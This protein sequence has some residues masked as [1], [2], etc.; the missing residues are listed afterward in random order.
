MCVP[1]N[2]T[3]MK[4][5]SILSLISF[6]LF[7]CAK[8]VRYDIAIQNVDVF[9]SQHKIV[10]QNKTILIKHDSIVAIV[11]ADK[12]ISAAKKIEGKGRLVTSGFVDTHIHLRQMLDLAD[13]NA[14]KVL[15]QTYRKKLAQKLLNFGITTALDMGQYESWIPTTI[16][17]QQNPS[18][19]YPNYYVT[20]AGMIS[21]GT[22]NPAPHHMVV[23][24]PVNKMQQYEKLGLK[25]VKLH[26]HLDADDMIILVEEATKRNMLTFLHCDNNRVTIQEA[27]LMG[28]R[29]FEHFFTVIP[30]VLDLDV[31][32]ALMEKRF[33]LNSYDHVDDFAAS[34]NFYF[35]YIK[36]KP[37]LEEKLFALFDEMAKNKASLSTT[38]HVLGAAAEK[39]SFFSSFITFPIRNKPHYP[40][41]SDKQK[42]DLKNAFD[43]MMQ[44]LKI[45]HDKGVKIRIGTDNREAGQSMASELMLLHAAGF[46]MEEIL[47]IA[48]WNGA[49][50]MGIEDQ[51]GSVREGMK[52]DLIIF[53]HSPLNDIENLFSEKTIIKGGKVYSKMD[54]QVNKSLKA[55]EMQGSNKLLEYVRSNLNKFEAYELLEIAYHLFH[56]GEIKSGESVLNLLQSKFPEFRELYYEDAINRIGHELA[57]Q[58][59]IKEAIEIFM[60]NTEKFPFSS[61]ALENLAQAYE[62]TGQKELAVKICK[63]WLELAPENE[64]VQEMLFRLGK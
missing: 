54:D 13:R 6:C 32:N 24:D 44:Y 55:L 5:Y 18:P 29:N 62:Y 25:H 21:E 33:E 63:K 26:S 14:P 17:W 31:H 49:E 41:Y 36:E 15:D 4:R 47:K 9:E 61:K 12:K 42:Q 3:Y 51:I 1:N 57:D 64:V 40:N 28:V 19:D 34:M 46:S 50:A 59:M 37:E 2:M 20:G 30:S 27:M 35:A 16:D 22:K 48:T 39:T 43:I 53:D 23:E 10:S 7:S 11:G 52:A 45:A 38:I 56:V 60:F 8:E 58:E